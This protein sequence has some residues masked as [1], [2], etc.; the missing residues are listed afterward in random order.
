MFEYFTESAIETML[1]AQKRGQNMGYLGVEHLLFAMSSQVNR[2]ASSALHRYGVTAEKV[3]SELALLELGKALSPQSAELVPLTPRAKEAL[4]LAWN[5]A[6][7]LNHN[8]INT[9]HLLLGLLRE[10]GGASAKILEKLEVDSRELEEHVLAIVRRE[11]P[12]KGEP[13]EVG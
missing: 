10:G 4:S 2:I 13:E 1:I 6:R 5:A 8:Y 12:F 11:S 3:D 7:D 9:E